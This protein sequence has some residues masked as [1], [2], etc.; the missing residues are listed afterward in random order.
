MGEKNQDELLRVDMRTDPA[1]HMSAKMPPSCVCNTVGSQRASP[2]SLHAPVH[3]VT[4]AMRAGVAEGF[5]LH[6]E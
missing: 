5:P 2:A 4:M 3:M 6:P 1:W